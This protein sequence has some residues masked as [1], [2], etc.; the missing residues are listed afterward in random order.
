MK[1]LC[2][3]QTVGKFDMIEST[4]YTLSLPS[5]ERVMSILYIYIHKVGWIA[6]YEI[7]VHAFFHF[8]PFTSGRQTARRISLILWLILFH[9][10]SLLVCVPYVRLPDMC[11]CVCLRSP[12]KQS[13]PK[14]IRSSLNLAT[15]AKTSK[16]WKPER[17]SKT[18][19]HTD[20]HW[21]T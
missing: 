13:P 19:S 6:G 4:A 12:Y 7:V 9:S 14:S 11:M 5:G 20:T 10:N 3:K 17:L 16:T 15:Q 1:K 18:F 21:Q 8:D 2:H